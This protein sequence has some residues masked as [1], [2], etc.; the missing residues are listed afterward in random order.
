M[1][2]LLNKWKKLP[3][4]VKSSIAFVFSSLIV[5]GFIFI[6]TPIFTRIMDINDYGI[7]TTYNSWIS[8]IEI[9]AILGLTSAGVFNVGLKDNKDTRNEYISSCL[10]LC[11]ITTLIVFCII[12]ILKLIFGENFILENKYLFIMFIHFLFNPAQIFWITRQRYEY[13]YKFSTIISIFSVL[14][15]QLLSVIFVLTSKNDTSFYKILG[16]ELG[17]LIFAIPIYIVLLKRGKDYV[18]LKRWKN[19]LILALPLIPHYLSQ[20]IMDSSDKIMISNMVNSGDAA[21]YG[22]VANISMIGTIFWNAINASLVPYTFD[23]IENKK[24]RDIDN[25]CQKLLV[26]Y[27]IVLFMI[28]LLA[29]EI[30]SILAPSNYH[31][32]IYCV[33]PLAFVMFLHALYNL[34]ANIEFYNKK[35]NNIAI[36]TVLATIINLI[37]NYIFIPKY[38]FIAASYTTLVSNMFLVFFHYRGYKNTETNKIYDSKFILLLSII[39]LIFI[40]LCN[41]LYLNN[42]IRYLFILIILLFVYI[43]R[44]ELLSGIK[45]VMKKK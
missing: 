7:V 2:K 44:R 36:A 1:K 16:N 15:A 39:F 23:K 28:I 41:I 20:H 10:G 14:T 34:F 45:T 31:K 9:F 21:I 22:V 43:K 37:L 30:L 24:Y 40:G 12:V 3:N 6:V 42:Y 38:S 13:K 25:L 32:G 11:N 4:S 19:I 8:I 5:K 29:P 27:L 35:T 18:N 26:G 17:I 33:P